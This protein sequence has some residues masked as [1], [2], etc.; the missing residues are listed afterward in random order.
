[1]PTLKCE[2]T[3]RAL[4]ESS[5]EPA[6]AALEPAVA[7]HLER[8]PP[9]A[10][11]AAAQHELDDLLMAGLAP[12]R[13]SPSFRAALHRQIDARAQASYADAL[14]DVLHLAGC[15]TFMAVG[16]TMLPDHAPVILAAGTIATVMTHLL[17]AVMRNTLD[18]SAR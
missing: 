4:L 11:I 8:C 2:E 10:R 14:P 12:P 7:A 18:E 6:V 15:A 3:Q 16:A 5:D 1:M 9:C 17:L 13:L